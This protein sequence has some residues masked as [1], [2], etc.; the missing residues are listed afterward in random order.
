MEI[1]IDDA[2]FDLTAFYGD[3]VTLAECDD[4]DDVVALWLLRYREDE[5]FR[6]YVDGS[7]PW[8]LRESRK[9]KT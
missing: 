6:V 2:V 1:R 3:Q 7:L 8:Y 9:L 5:D 4:E